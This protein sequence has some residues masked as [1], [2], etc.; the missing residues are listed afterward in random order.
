MKKPVGKIGEGGEVIHQYESI[1]EAARRCGVHPSGISH[2]LRGKC[3]AA[4]FYWV[5]IK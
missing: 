3:R 2:S 1:A 4:G 5:Y